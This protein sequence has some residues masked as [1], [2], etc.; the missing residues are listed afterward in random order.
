MIWVQ[1]L[2][3]SRSR[4]IF[5]FRHSQRDQQA[6]PAACTARPEKE[7]FIQIGIGNAIEGT[8]VRKDTVISFTMPHIPGMSTEIL[9]AV[10][11]QFPEFSDLAKT[12]QSF[13]PH[14]A[15]V[16]TFGQSTEMVGD[17]ALGRLPG[18]FQLI[19]GIAE[20]NRD[21]M[22]DAA[23]EK[24]ITRLR[25]YS[26]M[27]E[28]LIRDGS[29]ILS[30]PQHGGAVA[31]RNSQAFG[32]QHLYRMEWI[33]TAGQIMTPAPPHQG[34]KMSVVDEKLSKDKADIDYMLALLAFRVY[35]YGIGA[36]TT[37]FVQ[38]NET[39]AVADCAGNKAYNNFYNFGANS[40][41]NNP[42]QPNATIQFMMDNASAVNGGS[43]SSGGGGYGVI[44]SHTCSKCGKSLDKDQMI[45]SCQTQAEHNAKH[46]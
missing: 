28:N 33:D 27:S 35:A 45:C 25:T 16:A 12:T 9:G 32:D 37:I 19:S 18:V 5:D 14:D 6:A 13:H 21:S 15:L 20:R 10:A 7:M 3:K 1:V 26:M 29:T 36:N 46:A 31:Y 44:V 4:R 23:F 42:N 17:C 43:S 24:L 41:S 22:S 2:H 11:S 8:A 30:N 34:Y 38:V 39:A 40:S